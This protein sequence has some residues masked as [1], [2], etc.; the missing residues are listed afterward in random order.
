MKHFYV[1]L[2]HHPVIREGS[3]ITSSVTNLDI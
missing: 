2:I 3:V 1:A